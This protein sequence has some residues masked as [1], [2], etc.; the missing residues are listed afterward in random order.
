MSGVTDLRCAPA[1]SLADLLDGRPWSAAELHGEPDPAQAGARAGEPTGRRSGARSHEFARGRLCARRALRGLG[2]E[3]A[4]VGIGPD[5]E[6]LWPAGVVGSITHTGSYAAAV[7]AHASGLRSPGLDAEP[8]RPMSEVLAAEVLTPLE[9]ARLRDAGDPA[10]LAVL[11]F[12]A[13]EAAFKAW[14]P[15]HRQWIEHHHLAVRTT[16]PGRLVVEATPSGLAELGAI[17]PFPGRAALMSRSVPTVVVAV[18][19]PAASERDG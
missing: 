10:L 12:A 19:A 3:E 13:K 7:V 11:C 2:V 15:L 5:G 1:G 14:F 6:P 4:P 17:G 8:V 18:S 16:G 9:R